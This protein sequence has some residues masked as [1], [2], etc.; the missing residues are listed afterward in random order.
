MVRDALGICRGVRWTSNAAATLHVINR[1]MKALISRGQC[2]Q[3][4]A[5]FDEWTGK[6]EAME[7]ESINLALKCCMQ[8]GLGH[9]A[10]QIV[11]KH[12]GNKPVSVEQVSL[13]MN[14]QVLI[15]PISRFSS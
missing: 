15:S 9:R 6:S 8:L 12:I 10:M 4:L 1:Q 7:D 3:A 2:R 13:I 11:D 14:V 5:M